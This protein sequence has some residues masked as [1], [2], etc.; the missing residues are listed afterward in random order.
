M[1]PLVSICIPTYNGANYLQEA[2][3]SV[4]KQTYKNIDV[5]ISDDASIDE[6]LSIVNK[7]K[8]EVDFPV[9]IFNHNPSG[10]GANWNN[11]VKKAKGEF[12]K[13][14]HQDDVLYQ[15][16][17]EKM[18]SITEKDDNV[19]L[20]YC[21]RKIIS[22]N[23]SKSHKTWIKTYGELH[24]NLETL[25][26]LTG[27]LHGKDYLKDKKLLNS[28]LNKIGEPTATLLHKD[29]FN[30]VGYFSSKLK[31]TLD[32]EYWYR[33]MPFFNIGFVDEDLIMIRLHS[34]QATWINEKEGT[35]DNWLLP[36]ILFR[37]IFKYLHP[38]QKK[39]LF[40]NIIRNSQ[41]YSLYQSIKS[42]LKI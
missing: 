31:Q 38:Y 6:T 12:I 23:N 17:I 14:L 20:V 24:T 15:E 40:L 13:F 25:Y 41:L 5:V 1:N 16:C 37:N 8:K 2:L 3:D 19:G 34:N 7:F 35:K 18:I 9:Y 4:K 29:V 22:E 27:V 42:K 39:N 28:P 21:R 36:L 30:K 32:L 26:P 33:L 11:C 10:I